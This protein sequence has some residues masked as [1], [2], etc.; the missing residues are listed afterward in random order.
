M[1]LLR[2]D[3]GKPNSRGASWCK[4]NNPSYKYRSASRYE[5]IIAT[6]RPHKADV[7]LQGGDYMRMLSCVRNPPRRIIVDEGCQDAIPIRSL[8]SSPRTAVDHE[9]L[10][11]IQRYTMITLWIGL[12][13][14]RYSTALQSTPSFRLYR[15]DNYRG[16]DAAASSGLS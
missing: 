1:Y 2:R 5:R 12:R 3:Q 16:R 14:T 10:P 13:D 11:L 6:Q 9:V 15:L 8:K 4:E 7:R